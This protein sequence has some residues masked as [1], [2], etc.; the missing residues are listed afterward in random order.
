MHK[1]LAF[2]DLGGWVYCDEA[3]VSESGGWMYF[4]K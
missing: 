3:H 2:F 4:F 1:A